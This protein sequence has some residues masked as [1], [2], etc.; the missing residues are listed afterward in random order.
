MDEQIPVARTPK[1]F[2]GSKNITIYDPLYFS[3]LFDHHIY[4]PS[5]LPLKVDKCG[6]LMYNLMV[7][8]S[9]TGKELEVQ[10]QIPE[11]MSQTIKLQSS[12][13]ENGQLE[14]VW[15]SNDAPSNAFKADVNRCLEYWLKLIQHANSFGPEP[16]IR[17]LPAACI[18]KWPWKS[19]SNEEY[20][21]KFRSESQTHILRMGVGYYASD[22][23]S[24]GVSLQLGSYPGKTISAASASK[25][26]KR[27]K[28]SSEE[29]GEVKTDVE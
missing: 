5:I 7:R 27:K 16:D 23:N 25:T 2:A 28:V 11:S 1:Y 9:N 19:A 26:R 18:L 17:F 12:D 22:R 29:E 15:E 4:T 24:V 21:R 10:F 6:V 3:T 20:F 13:E 8:D 14:V